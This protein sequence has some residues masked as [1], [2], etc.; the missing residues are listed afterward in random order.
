M[1]WK[2]DHSQQAHGYF[3]CLWTQLQRHAIGP[4]L[5]SH[6]VTLSRREGKMFSVWA[7]GVVDQDYKTLTLRVLPCVGT[8]HKHDDADNKALGPL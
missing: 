8:S 4:P 2:D 3:T 5:V 7:E 1:T 6:F